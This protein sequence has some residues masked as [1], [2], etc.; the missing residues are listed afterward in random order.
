LDWKI[1]D[2]VVAKVLESFKNRGFPRTAHAGNDD[3]FSR[4]LSLAQQFLSLALGRCPR[5]A[6]LPRPHELDGSI[7]A[8]WVK[9]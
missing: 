7:E 2:T 1:V 9:Q 6:D 4:V 5:P 3:K 8:P